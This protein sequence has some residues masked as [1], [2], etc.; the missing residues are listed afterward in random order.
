MFV[1]G[2]PMHL[3]AIP[4]L[5]NSMLQPS[6]QEREEFFSV[7]WNDASGVFRS[8]MWHSSAEEFTDWCCKLTNPALKP[9]C[10]DLF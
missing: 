9:E 4:A 3:S 6:K 2:I 10:N 8:T 7:L 5:F 1:Q